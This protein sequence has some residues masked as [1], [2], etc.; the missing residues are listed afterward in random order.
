MSF[1]GDANFASLVGHSVTL[2]LVLEGGAHLYAL[3]FAEAPRRPMSA[4]EAFEKRGP[5][6]PAG[7]S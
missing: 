3:G 6:W 4:R 2:E 7:T 5:N 1:I